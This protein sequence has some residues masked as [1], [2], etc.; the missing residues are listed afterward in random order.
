MILNAINFSSLARALQPSILMQLKLSDQ[1]VHRFEVSLILMGMLEEALF[2]FLG[3]VELL[4][5]KA[6]RN[7]F[8][9]L[10]VSLRIRGIPY[11]LK[12]S[13]RDAFQIFTNYLF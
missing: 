10:A 3:E 12:G 4:L 7:G 9:S 2:F 6:Y 13:L 5:Q 1:T 11:H 8:L